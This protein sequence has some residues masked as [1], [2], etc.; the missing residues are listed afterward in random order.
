MVEL[1]WAGLV[2]VSH[3]G[4]RKGDRFHADREQVDDLER[5]A[6]R[7]GARLVVLD[8]ELDVSG[9]LPL[10]QRPALLAAVEGVERGEYAGIMVAY[11]SRLGRNVREQLRAWDRVEAAGGRIVVVREGIDTS[12]AAGR[13][14]RNLLLSIAEHERE[15]H[16]ERFELRR[17]LATAAGIWQ[18]RQT[19]TGYQR[20][21]KTRRLVPDERADV[22]REAFRAKG[23]GASVV[24]IAERL[25]MTPA[26][27]R[28]LLDNRVYLGELRVGRHVNPDAHEPLVT[29]E[30]W[31]AAQ[32]RA[33]R[34][35]RKH[36]EPALL[37]GLIRCQACGH[38]MTRSSNNGRPNYRCPAKHSA[39]TCPSPATVMCAAADEYVT[40]IA[41][42]ELEALPPASPASDDMPLDEARRA[43]I[44]AERELAAYLEAVSAVDVGAEAFAA[45]ARVRQERVAEA[46]GAE[47]RL[48]AART[49]AADVAAVEMWDEMSVA[50]RNRVLRGLVEVVVARRAVRRG[51]P[52]DERLQVLA[53]GCGLAPIDRG[54]GRALPVAEIPWLAA[55]DPAVLGP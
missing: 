14:Q 51:Q 50:H 16:A 31:Q 53:G 35:P 22:V 15:Q 36:A 24:S 7:I 42:R 26:G 12:T 21:A 41:L 32:G 27:A 6:S 49:T 34:R 2:R 43:V 55:D 37:A 13:L 4:G 3:V 40:R 48:L 23:A 25:G 52:L 30:E 47:A 18:R 38:V 33:A 29:L 1:P 28:A 46:R 19:P 54:G 8:P 10:E 20:D 9:G 17:Q 44:A 39:Q 5:E 45:G 11:L